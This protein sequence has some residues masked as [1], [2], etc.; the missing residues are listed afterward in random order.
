MDDDVKSELD[1]IHEQLGDAKNRLDVLEPELA[2]LKTDTD[3]RMDKALNNVAARVE[4]IEK[5]LD[6]IETY[7]KTM[8]P[9][10]LMSAV[11]ALSGV[12]YPF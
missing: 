8:L 10:Q 7:L 1:S 5:R 9:P 11:P 6:N 3:D 2:Q 12:N 4:A